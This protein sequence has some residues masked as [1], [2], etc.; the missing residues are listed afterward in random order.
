M[1]TGPINEFMQR[2]HRRLEELLD[3]ADCG[4]TIEFQPYHAFRAGLLRHIGMEEKILLPAAQ[5][6]RGAE[7]LPEKR[8]LRLDHAALAALLVPTPTPSIVAK[9]REVLAA[10]NAIEEGPD[11]VYAVCEK[12]I[13]SDAAALLERLER[14]PPVS[15]APYQDGLRGMESIRNCLRAAGRE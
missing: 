8:Q 6:A 3:A 13:G 10:H 1:S 4:A 9:L 2:D 7:P 15:L 14:A 5:R 11:G 12:L